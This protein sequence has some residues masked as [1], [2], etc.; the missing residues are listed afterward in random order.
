MAKKPLPA[1][2]EAKDLV[3]VVAKVKGIV[4]RNQIRVLEFMEGF[5]THRE[6]CI[7]ESD[8]RRGLDAANVRLAV[9]EVDQ[10]CM[11]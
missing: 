4:S 9:S 7:L 3:Q 10:L 8:F 2:S 6:V 5:D 11:A 1:L